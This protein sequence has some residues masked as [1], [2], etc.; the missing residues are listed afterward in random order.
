MRSSSGTVW[1]DISGFFL[2]P[3]KR[4]QPAQITVIDMLGYLYPAVQSKFLHDVVDMAFYGVGR[5]AEP[6]G[7]C[8]VAETVGYE[9]DNFT[10]TFVMHFSTILH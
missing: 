8:L 9:G 10:L 3:R 4:R 7:N 1:I 5:D 6:L 2:L